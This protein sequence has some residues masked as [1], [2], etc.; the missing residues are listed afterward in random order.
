MEFD[1]VETEI[2]TL[3]EPV[4]DKVLKVIVGNLLSY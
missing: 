2:R 4:G 1:K 3:K